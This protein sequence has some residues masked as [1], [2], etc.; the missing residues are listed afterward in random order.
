[1]ENKNLSLQESWFIIKEIGLDK[2]Y[3]ITQDE[4]EYI[5]SCEGKELT[6]EEIKIRLLAYRKLKKSKN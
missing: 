4:W 5:S 6:E 1:M 2:I 3:G